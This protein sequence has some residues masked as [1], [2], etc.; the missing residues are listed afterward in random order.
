MLMDVVV[1]FHWVRYLLHPNTDT[2][3]K[4]R[5]AASVLS[6]NQVSVT[7]AAPSYLPTSQAC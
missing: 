1:A 2:H 6:V 7:V 4:A 3:S 5:G